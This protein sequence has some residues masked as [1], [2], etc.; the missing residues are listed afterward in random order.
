MTA[1][2]YSDTAWAQFRQWKAFAMH[3]LIAGTA[4]LTLSL[5]PQGPWMV[6]GHPDLEPFTDNRGQPN[7]REVLAPLLD[8]D[9][10]PYLPGSSLKGVL[11]STAERILRSM[12]PDRDP[13][14]VPL[15]DD[16]FVHEQGAVRLPALRSQI[17]DSELIEWLAHQPKAWLAAHPGY[18]QLMQDSARASR[19]IY[20]ALSPASQLFGCT[21]HAGLVML[22]AARD[23]QVARQRRSHVAVDRF[24]GGV[25]AGPF[26]EDLAAAGAPLRTELRITN[27]ALWQIALL[28]LT[29]QELNRGY[30][31]FGGGTR[32][33][34]GQ[35]RLRVERIEVT[36]PD[37]AY[38]G[39]AG[40]IISA[41]A[42]LAASPWSQLVDEVPLVVRT[43]E[44]Q[45]PLLASL[46]PQSA[47]WRAEGLTTLLV[48]EDTVGHLFRE[49]TERAWQPWVRAMR[50]EDAL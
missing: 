38:A 28:G 6:R 30:Q 50:Q 8:H 17:A 13:A 48:Q 31:G 4:T 21:L 23:T 11:R 2:L 9:G 10:V 47:D 40:G 43:V 15:A 24:S 12:H 27:F 46:E 36:Y 35:V 37:W 42:A 19:L 33:G 3:R 45:P 22:D 32:K 39:T 25:G 14:W 44:A 26:I 16:P 20:A 49:A 7:Q 5:T 1:W 18:E 29:F 41:Q 34:Q